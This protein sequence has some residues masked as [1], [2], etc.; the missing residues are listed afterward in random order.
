MQIESKPQFMVYFKN[1]LYVCIQT[2]WIVQEKTA[3]LQIKD[4][5]NV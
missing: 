4:Q 5:E 3:K 2:S 1:V